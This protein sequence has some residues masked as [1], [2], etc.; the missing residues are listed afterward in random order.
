MCPA[1][2]PTLL[3]LLLVAA[4]GTQCG[5]AQQAIVE[6]P[7]QLRAALS[8]AAVD[9]I[10]L[11]QQVSLDSS[12][13]SPVTVA[14]T[15]VMASDGAY[16][17]LGFGNTSS[18]LLSVGPGGNMTLQ[19]LT[20]RSFYPAQP[21]QVTPA[22]SI[23]PI[24]SVGISRDSAELH[25]QSCVFHV[26]GQ[27]KTVTGPMPFWSTVLQEASTAVGSTQQQVVP[28][29]AQMSYFGGNSS[30]TVRK[31]VL[32]MDP[33][34]CYTGQGHLTWDSRSLWN[35]VQKPALTHA[36]V[37]VNIS[38]SAQ[39]FSPLV[40]S[41]VGNM[42]ISGCSSTALNFNQ[43]HN[44]L[45]MQQGATL[46]F[47][48]PLQL[49]G[50][51]TAHLTSR[52]SNNSSGLLLLGSVDISSGARLLL[53]DVEV[54]VSNSSSVLQDMRLFT[55]GTTA[56]AVVWQLPAATGQRGFVVQSWDA[57][58][59]GVMLPQAVVAAQGELQ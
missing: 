51:A 13:F 45:A 3:V 25:L 9:N 16:G 5:Y 29:S 56:P 33:S 39:H 15:I 8:D 46:Q 19:G 1:G 27:L 36:V 52:N 57:D 37:F 23:M 18:V 53:Q 32:A 7:A 35:A 10:V 59:S 41:P 6:N 4:S 17:C 38:L 11:P 28:V 31:S 21:L 49:L 20:V 58:L 50:A 22:S 34:G 42:T 14:R 40:N 2:L 43:L 24:A 26:Q 47:M 54:G 12:V 55:Q 30:V 44:A 48:G